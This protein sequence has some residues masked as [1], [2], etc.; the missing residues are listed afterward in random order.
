MSE[1]SPE[2]KGGNQTRV[3]LPARA[4]GL[5]LVALVARPAGAQELSP[6]ASEGVVAMW[7]QNL[8]EI[9]KLLVEREWKRA[10]R[11]AD[12]LLDAVV[13]RLQA[14]SGAGPLLASAVAMRAIAH[15]GL[16]DAEGAAWDWHVALS[17]SPSV[18]DV[19][20]TRFG[21][22]G[23]Y[24]RSAEFERF[25]EKQVER[26]RES[27]APGAARGDARRGEPR[28]TA[29]VKVSTPPPTYP[30]AKR[31]ACIEQPVMLFFVID[32]R[33]RPIAPRF[34]DAADPVLAFSA[35]ETIREWRFEPATTDGWPLAIHYSQTVNYKM[36]F[37]RD[38]RAA[39][40]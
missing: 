19:D 15:S 13:E 2:P 8:G 23:S 39:G 4:L 3:R 29:P 12:G 10:K 17:L 9:E 34:G 26:S 35:L 36:L 18:Q 25:T 32:T 30:R 22:A 27:K 31:N 38:P 14:G 28:S 1:A 16:G 7:Q 6:A 11:K 40:E 5:V 37:C 21:D 20:L 24:F 33:G